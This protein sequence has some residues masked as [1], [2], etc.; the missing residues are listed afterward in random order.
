M[1]LWQS[2]SSLKQIAKQRKHGNFTDK[3]TLGAYDKIWRFLDANVSGLKLRA[4]PEGK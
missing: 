3:D 1:T 2:P 4:T